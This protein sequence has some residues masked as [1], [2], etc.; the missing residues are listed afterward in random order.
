MCAGLCARLERLGRLSGVVR[1]GGI[2]AT[3]PVKWQ[4]GEQGS[5]G[6]QGGQGCFDGSHRRH[7]AALGIGSQYIVLIHR[8][9]GLHVLV[10]RSGV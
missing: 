3:H 2:F 4:P 8:G 1:P 9:I 10:T 6:G 7:R 5:Q